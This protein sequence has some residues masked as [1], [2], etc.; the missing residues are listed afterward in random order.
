MVQVYFTTATYDE[1]ERDKKVT[2]ESQLGVVGGTMGLLTGFSLLSLVEIFYFASKFVLSFR[3]GKKTRDF[4]T[5]RSVPKRMSIQ[6]VST[7]IV[8]VKSQYGVI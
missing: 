2:L 7:G 6:S 4:D 3:G 8:Q 5:S 1:I